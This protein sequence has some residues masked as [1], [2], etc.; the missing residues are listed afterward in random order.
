[1]L[2][3]EPI[4]KAKHRGWAE[5]SST[6]IIQAHQLIMAESEEKFMDIQKDIHQK[7]SHIEHA[8]GDGPYF[9]GTSFGLVDAAYAPFFKRIAEI[10]I[11]LALE[12][13]DNLPNIQAWSKALL[14][15]KSVQDSLIKDFSQQYREYIKKQTSYL[16][17]HI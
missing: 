6:L 17:Q 13:F 8:I 12:I 4:E 16:A 14:S 15:R 11:I 9:M 3:S 5:I 7:L 2:P 10:N 1:M